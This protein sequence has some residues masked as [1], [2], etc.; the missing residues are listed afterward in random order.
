MTLKSY[1]ASTSAMMVKWDAV[2]GAA[3][4]TLEKYENG[5]WTTVASNFTNNYKQF[6]A[7]GAETNLRVAAYNASGSKLA[8]KT[9][10]VTWSAN[11]NPNPNPGSGE[12]TI[13][14]A[15][16]LKSYDASTKA[17]MVKWDAV[18]GASTYTLEKCVN[19]AWT[20]VASNFAN[21]Y[22][23]FTASGAETNLRVAAYNASGAKLATKTATV[24][25]SAN[26]GNNSD[27]SS[28]TEPVLTGTVTKKSYNEST[29]ALMLKWDPIS[30]ASTYTLQKY[31]NGAWTNIASKFTNTY[32]QVTVTQGEE[33]KFRVLAYNASGAQLTTTR[34]ST[35]TWEASGPSIVS[36]GIT[37]KTY[38][39]AAG[40][41]MLKWDAISGAAT[42]SLQ[43]STNNGSTWTTV[44]SGFTNSYKQV[45][46]ITG[47]ATYQYRVCGVTS[48]G[49]TI[50]GYVS[51]SITPASSSIVDEAFADFF[52]EDGL[53]EF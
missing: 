32:K 1:D 48:A 44:A 29:G 31:V 39:E 21:N 51:C 43:K 41:A 40:T 22:K 34:L 14:G 45:S 7:S 33:C 10:T 36:N 17:L 27:D 49:K 20:T 50:S 25:W 26:P 3:K 12:P 9:A 15:M 42:Y 35:L 4:Y 6:T 53:D 19:G 38:D 28:K 24:T 30:G 46:G 13:S 18:S 2:S 5:A 23:Q 16:T 11:P 37:V 8:T 47:T 52:A